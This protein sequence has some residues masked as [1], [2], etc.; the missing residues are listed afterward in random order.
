MLN[1][2]AWGYPPAVAEES[3]GFLFSWENWQELFIPSYGFF[4]IFSLAD[5]PEKTGFSS[6]RPSSAK[7]GYEYCLAHTPVPLLFELYTST[8]TV[9]DCA[10]TKGVYFYKVSYQ[11]TSYK[12]PTGA[13]AKKT[14][15]S[16]ERLVRT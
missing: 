16:R 10:S 4:P 11:T 14:G 9:I 1:V 2:V 15:L 7:L 6:P 8:R 5:E 13:G 3:D 12:N